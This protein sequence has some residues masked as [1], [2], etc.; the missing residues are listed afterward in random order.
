MDLSPSEA[1]AL[2]KKLK[3]QIQIRPMKGP[4]RYIAGSDISFNKFSP[5]VYAGFV[6]LDFKTLK[7]VETASAVMDVTFPYI[8]GLLSFREIPPLLEAWKK[9]KI[10]PDVL[11]FDGHGIAHPRRL[12]IAAHAGLLLKKPTIGCGKSLLTGVF[13]EPALEAGSE[14][15]LLD[16]KTKEQI[17]LVLRTKNKVKPIF[18]S[19]GHLM[20]FESA[21][22]IIQACVVKHRIPEPT[23]L[24]HLYVNQLRQ[25]LP[26]IDHQIQL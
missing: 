2:Q 17:G 18:V 8:P 21:R 15:P 11:V 14:S 20:D 22:K 16:K 1:V 19:P 5:T 13:E 6:V 3:D 12:G 23:R 25:E 9:L 7:I 24:A 10:S 4:I 26:L